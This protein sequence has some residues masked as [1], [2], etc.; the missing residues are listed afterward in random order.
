MQIFTS[1]QASQS[2]I[3]FL[4]FITACG[5]LTKFNAFP[6]L[7][8]SVILLWIIHTSLRVRLRSILLF[9]LPSIVLLTPYYLLRFLRDHSLDIAYNASYQGLTVKLAPT[10]YEIFTFNPFLLI[11]KPVM[12]TMDATSRSAL[13][14]ESLIKTAHFGTTF[15]TDAGLF[16]VFF[17]FVLLFASIGFVRAFFSPFG[18]QALVSFFVFLLS[19][20]AFRILYPYASAQHFRYIPLLLFPCVTFLGYSLEICSH[21]V[22]TRA[23]SEVLVGLYIFIIALLSAALIIVS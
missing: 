23:F 1:K 6:W 17:L 14:F 5:L 13:F 2:Q 7:I 11:A 15:P 8:L 18:R 9:S 19:L 22:L 20:L 16:L 10:F 21:R 4:G 3:L 12:N